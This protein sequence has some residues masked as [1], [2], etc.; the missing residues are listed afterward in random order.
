M[1]EIFQHSGWGRVERWV[2]RVGACG[3]VKV[4]VGLVGVWG[5]LG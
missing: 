1:L 4:R 3:V 2:G 5:R